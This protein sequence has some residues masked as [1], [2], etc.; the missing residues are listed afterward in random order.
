MAQTAAQKAWYEANKQRILDRKRVRDAASKE[1]KSEYGKEYYQLNKE[2]MR[3]KQAEY[4]Q[5]NREYLDEV[6][7]SW[8]EKNP[9]A[10]KLHKSKWKSLNRDAVNSYTQKRRARLA[11][12]EGSYKSSDVE[13]MVEGQQGTCNGCYC[14]LEFTGYHVD[15]I[16]PLSKGGS[17][18]PN[19]LQL[20]C[21]SCNLSK[22]SLMPLDWACKTKEI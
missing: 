12:A 6:N 14:N 13:S 11:G 7:K 5:E 19:N 17:N 8:A 4:Y 15:H 20:L 22:G 3:E 21:P 9:E 1:S 16:V 10:R 18:W 2:V